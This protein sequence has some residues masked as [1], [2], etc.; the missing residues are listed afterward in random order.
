[1]GKRFY[2]LL[3]EGFLRNR[4]GEGPGRQ[5][6]RGG[7]R[8]EGR[9][10]GLRRTDAPMSASPPPPCQAGSAPYKPWISWAVV[11]EEEEEGEGEEE[12]EK[13]KMMPLSCEILKVV[14]GEWQRILI[15]PFCHHQE[16]TLHFYNFPGPLRQ[17][18]PKEII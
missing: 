15:C 17:R 3:E 8:P 1:M 9:L 16:G 6:E 13:E 11:E 12:E 18:M 4:E 2:F 10:P 14:W 5:G 7:F